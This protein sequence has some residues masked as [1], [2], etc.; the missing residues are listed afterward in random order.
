MND[1]TR[2]VFIA[3]GVSLLVIVLVPLLFMM[4]MMSTMTGSM[5]GMMNGGWI[6]GGGFLLILVIGIALIALGMR[7]R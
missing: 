5:G 7:R 1:T 3:L 6:M 2:T 4:G